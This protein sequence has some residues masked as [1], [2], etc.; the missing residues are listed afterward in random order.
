MVGGW[1]KSGFIDWQNWLGNIYG[2][3]YDGKPN[4]HLHIFNTGEQLWLAF[5]MKEKYD[6]VWNGDDWTKE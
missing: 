2:F 4:G 1:P 6:K 5:V 3:N